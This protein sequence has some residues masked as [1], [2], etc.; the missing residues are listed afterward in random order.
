MK[1][2]KV[3]LLILDGWGIGDA[4]KSDAIFSANTPYIDSLYRNFPN[5]KLLAH[6]QNVGLPDG[7]MGNSEVGHSNIG[8]GRVLFQDLVRI[9]NDIASGVFFQ[10]EKLKQA[11]TYANQNK[12]AVHL[13]GLVSDGGVHSYNEHIYAILEMAARNDVSR[14]YVHAITDGRDTDPMSGIRYIQQLQDKMKESTGEIASLVGRFYTMDRDKRWERVKVGYDLYIE[15]K[16]T[17]SR[18]IEDAVQNSYNEGI[19]DEFI[20]PVVKV[21]E[22]GNPVGLIH[23]E[24]VVICFNY[25][26]DRMREITTALTQRDLEEEGM[27]VIPLRYLTM[28]SYDDSYTGVEVLYQNDNVENTLGE[29]IAKNNLNQ[30]RIAETE[31]YPHVTFFFSGG[32]E[33]P[34]EQEDRIFVN[35]PKVAT[36][37]L[38]PEMSAYEITEKLLAALKSDKYQFICLNYANCDMV[39]HTGV[40]DAIIQAVQTVDQCVAQVIETAREMGYTAIL[41]ADHGNSDFAINTDGTPNTEHSLN[42]VPCIIIGDNILSVKDGVLADLAPTILQIMGIEKPAEMTGLSLIS[43]P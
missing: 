39:G 26:A 3:I 32:R 13:I 40:Y 10:N 43:K 31:K 6:G 30:L 14:V 15:G 29:V 28:T 17:K 4:S 36:Y 24:D 8:A 33:I 5:S 25:R 16:G 7:Q 1:T 21:D 18:N 22:A 20:K 2:N 19:T 41:T 12:K 27:K 23:P 35:S 9:N 38:K 42:P 37:D 34:F 11:F